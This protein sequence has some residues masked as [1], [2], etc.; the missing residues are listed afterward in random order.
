MPLNSVQLY[1]QSVLSGISIPGQSSPLQV[2]ITPPVVDDVNGPRAYIWAG[3]LDPARRQ[4]APRGPAFKELNW[5]LDIYLNY[6][7]NPDDPVSGT[8]GVDSE[9]PLVVDAVMAA[10]WTTAMPV[11]ITDPVTGVLSQILSIGESFRMD[12]PPER[13]PATLRMLWY[14]TVITMDVMEVVQA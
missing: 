13:T 4:T 7:T 11:F 9:F 14:S 3:R 12:Y 10:T 1:V 8:G 5:L 6:E 2:Y